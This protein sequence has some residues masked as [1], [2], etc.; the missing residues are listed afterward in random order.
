LPNLNIVTRGGAKTGAHADNLPQIQKETLKEC[1]YDALKQKLFFKNAIEVF[2]NIPIPEIQEKPPQHIV[3]PN[4]AQVLSSPISPRN[5]VVTVRQP[6][7]PQNLVDLWFQLFSDI[8]GNDQLTDKLRNVL[9]L[10]LGNEEP[11]ETRIRTNLPKNSAQ[12]V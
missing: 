12:R 2:Q 3:Y 10:V 7:Q 5:P 1:R 4:I 8:L 6:E 11:T 9:Y